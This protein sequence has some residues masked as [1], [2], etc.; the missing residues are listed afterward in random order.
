MFSIDKK[1]SLADFFDNSKNLN[2]D[3]TRNDNLMTDITY[4]NE[5]NEE[6]YYDDIDIID[7][8]YFLKENNNPLAQTFGEF[9]NT[10]NNKEYNI[11]LCIYR[12]NTDCKIPFVEFLVDID[13]VPQFPNV[14]NFSCPNIIEVNNNEPV[15]EHNTYFMNKC[16]T[17]LLEVLKLYEIFGIEL[18]KKMYKGFV[19]QDD[20]NIFVVFECL[21]E[22]DFYPTNNVQWI[23]LDEILFKKTINKKKID[24]LL[25]LFFEKQVYMTELYT[26]DTYQ[27][28]YP[29]PSLM[30]LC[31]KDQNSSK[32]YT[33]AKELLIDLTILGVSWLGDCYYFSSQI[34]NDIEEPYQKYAVFTDKSIYILRDIS[35]ITEIQIENFLKNNSIND[36]LTTYFNEDGLCLWCIKNNNT[37]TRI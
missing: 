5:D 13:D 9:N 30:Y 25:G 26:D 19:E 11:F 24:P 29:L 6:E 32:Y 15:E 4:Q 12:V 36:I 7:Q 16:L 14:S 20:S 23:I 1:K 27:H 3:T 35:K 18:L 10:E 22:T 37:F 28:Q 17:K 21:P 8:Y 2:H 33:V 34:I 31:G